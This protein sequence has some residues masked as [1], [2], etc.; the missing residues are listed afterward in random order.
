MSASKRKPRKRSQHHQQVEMMLEAVARLDLTGP[1]AEP[2][3]RITDATVRNGRANLAPLPASRVDGLYAMLLPLAA[4]SGGYWWSAVDPD[5]G[6][7]VA[8]I[9][10]KVDPVECADD[11]AYALN[12][13]G[14]QGELAELLQLCDTAMVPCPDCQYWG[15]T[16]ILSVRRAGDE[17]AVTA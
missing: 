8:Y 16:H 12:T 2:L 13:F 5:T 10:S 7:F 15:R 11:M 3:R 6:R 9:K 17:Y 14:P 4:S 1:G